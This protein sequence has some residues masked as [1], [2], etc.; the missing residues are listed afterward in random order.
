MSNLFFITSPL[1]L[2]NATEA[3]EHFKTTNN[4][5]VVIFTEYESKN[6][7]QISSLINEQEWDNVIRFDLRSKNSK[8]TFLRQI[9]LVK[10]LKK[11][12]YDNIFCGNYSSIGK[13]ILASVRKNKVYLLDDGA[14]T[15]TQHLIDLG[16]KNSHKERPFK[17]RFGNGALISSA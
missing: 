8:T 11:E 4:V 1:Q 10:A 3:R 9:Q 15:I 6:R 14:V 12:V 5:L 2:I 16:K 17:K 13:M 7:N